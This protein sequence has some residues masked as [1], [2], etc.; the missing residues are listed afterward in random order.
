[1]VEGGPPHFAARWGVTEDISYEWGE[2]SGLA[3]R[4]GRVDSG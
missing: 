4:L 1:M 3:S 2:P